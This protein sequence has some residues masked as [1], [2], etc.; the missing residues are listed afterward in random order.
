MFKKSTSLTSL[1]V[2]AT[3]FMTALSASAQSYPNPPE[4]ENQKYRNNPCRDPW[5]TQALMTAVTGGRTPAGVG[6]DG[7]CNAAL[8][9]AGQWNSFNDLVQYV[10]ATQSALAQQNIAFDRLDLNGK[11]TITLVDTAKRQVLGGAVYQNGR[12]I[13]NDAGSM[14]AA[15]A[16]NMVAAGGGNMVAAGGGN[17]VAAGGGNMVA[18][19]AGNLSVVGPDTR[20]LN[21]KRTIRLPKG[22]IVIK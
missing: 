10:K 22:M 5:V 15:G 6:D 19:G 12:L 2:L 16:G 3:L 20:V 17:M 7:V 14:V 18:A 1:L 8:Y 11:I 13:G 4:S 21:S 9:N